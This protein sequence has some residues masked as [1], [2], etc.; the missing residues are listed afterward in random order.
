MHSPGKISALPPSGNW[1][2]WWL[3]GRYWGINIWVFSPL[4]L[5]YAIPLLLCC[6]SY[7]VSNLILS[8]CTSSLAIHLI[9]TSG[10]LGPR[11]SGEAGK[12]SIWRSIS[13]RLSWCMY[14]TC[15]SPS[16][17]WD[18]VEAAMWSVAACDLEMVNP[19]PSS[20]SR[21]SSCCHCCHNVRAGL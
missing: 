5:N 2:C 14:L 6:T 21:R 10:A 15:R 17:N 12:W 3:V 20:K 8:H 7:R 19:D 4:S 13:G 16:G 11:W 1:L 9:F 18:D